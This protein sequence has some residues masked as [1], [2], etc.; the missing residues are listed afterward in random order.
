[1]DISYSIIIPHKN[2]P[3]LLVRCVRSIPRR[4]DVEIVIVDDNSSPDK[5]DFSHFPFVGEE[6][7][8]VI[9]DKTGLGAGHARNV[10]ICH[11]HGRWLLFADADDFFNYCFDEALTRYQEATADI[12]YFRGNC[13]DSDT[14]E[15]GHR[16][17]KVLNRWIALMD[18]DP[19]R[20]ELMLRCNFGEPWCKMVKAELVRSHNI[21]FDE[22]PAR[23]DTHF[24]YLAGYYART[25]A[26]DPH[27]IYCVTVRSAS[28][29]RCKTELF[30]L[31]TIKVFG[32]SA[33]FFRE[34]KVPISER[35][36]LEQLTR[37]FWQNKDTYRQGRDYLL[38]IGYSRS[39]LRLALCYMSAYIVLWQVAF[40]LGTRLRKLVG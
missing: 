4:P 24:S 31:S 26:T 27:A 17:N 37:S 28:I 9:L 11:A 6:G 2:I 22:L 19:A 20:A 21:C 15:C 29:S 35:R 18:R 40:E 39:A 38:S 16:P 8:Q 7:V 1:M 32:T 34:H 14:Y 12:I 5:V 13:V 23:N 3:D 30:K 36:H 33:R 25:I 10:G